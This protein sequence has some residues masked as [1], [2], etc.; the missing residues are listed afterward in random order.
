MIC[1]HLLVALSMKPPPHH[2][3]AKEQSAFE[4]SPIGVFAVFGETSGYWPNSDSERK[5]EMWLQWSALDTCNKTSDKVFKPW[6]IK[7]Q[8]FPNVWLTASMFMKY[9]YYFLTGIFPL[10]IRISFIWQWQRWNRIQVFTWQGSKWAKLQRTAVWLKKH[11]L[12]PDYTF[13]WCKVQ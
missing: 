9:F 5:W 2:G 8:C 7:K 1:L 10:R 13:Y 3:W 11:T 4:K 12:I 6:R